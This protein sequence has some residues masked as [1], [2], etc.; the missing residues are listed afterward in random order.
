MAKPVFGIHLP[1][2]SNANFRDIVAYARRCEDLGFESVWVA[3]H[4][5]SGALGGIYEPLTSLAALSG[6]TKKVHLGTSVLIASLRNPV[7]LADITGTIQEASGGRF[8]LG[9]GVGWD[10]S[11]FET[12][13]VRFEK[14]GL[15]TDECLEIMRGLWKG[16]AFSFEGEHFTLKNARIGTPPKQLPPVWIGGNSHS[17]IRRA[18]RYD[19]W[20][21]T[22]PTLDEIRLGRA[23]LAQQAKPT[24]VHMVA[25][26]VYLVMQDTAAEAERSAKFLS[27]QTGDTISKIREWAI[28]GDFNAAKKRIIDYVDAGVEYFVFSLPFTKRYEESLKK[29]TRL[30]DEI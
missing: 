26:H 17:A 6:A 9:V 19:A 23:E 3:D 22:D 25:A 12:L 11:E 5:L 10:R 14:R 13:G 1:S 27:D 29:V 2:S 30:I 20:F 28:V 18:S 24:D 4:I 16:E 21:P 8:M 15:I 7:L